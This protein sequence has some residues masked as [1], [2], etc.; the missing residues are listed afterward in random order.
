METIEKAKWNELCA[1]H[2][3]WLL[4]SAKGKRL[5]LRNVCI[6]GEINK[7]LSNALFSHCT[8]KINE[9]GNDFE[10]AVLKGTNFHSCN[11]NGIR[12]NKCTIK[13]CLFWNC[14][15]IN[16]SF[17]GC[18]LY[19]TAFESSD[20]SETLFSKCN[21]IHSN[22]EKNL[23]YH[24]KFRNS[25]LYGT[26]CG[27]VDLSQIKSD[28]RIITIGPIGS[29]DDCTNYLVDKDWV[30]CG[31]W[32]E[33]NDCYY[34]GTLEAF[35][36][37]IKEEKGTLRCKQYELAIQTFKAYKELYKNIDKV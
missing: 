18:N 35:E 19:A 9:F 12:F 4:G 5:T 37:R 36:Q 15:L 32:S 24:T 25:S 14:D 20:L 11:L 3:E 28:E 30:W 22:F 2:K 31:C 6:Q 33:N 34:G 27:K 21:L 10:N 16:T 29:R 23:M 17:I 26:Y 13:G 7:N 1:L 8:F